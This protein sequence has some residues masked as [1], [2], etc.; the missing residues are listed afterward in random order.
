[1]IPSADI[2]DAPAAATIMALAKVQPCGQVPCQLGVV[3]TAHITCHIGH[4]ML[5]QQTLD[6]LGHVLPPVDKALVAL[7][8]PLGP[9]LGHEKL[10]DLLRAVVYHGTDLLELD[11]QRLLSPHACE[12]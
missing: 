12:L 8:A 11:P 9:E 7:N 4:N 3:Q 10:E 6:V 5:A 2:H 1:M